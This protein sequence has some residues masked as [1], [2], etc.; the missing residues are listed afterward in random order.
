[1]QVEG[2]QEF[3]L[4]NLLATGARVSNAYAT[5]PSEWDNPSKD[6]LIPHEA[7]VSHEI[8]AKGQPLMDGH[9]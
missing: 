2:Q 1:M 9:A 3:S 7:G 6:G 8:F 5:Y 4:L